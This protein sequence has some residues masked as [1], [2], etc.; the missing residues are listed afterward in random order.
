MR[1]S[2]ML[3]K[4]GSFWR[5]LLGREE[6]KGLLR[7]AQS[8]VPELSWLLKL[9]TVWNVSEPE[10]LT[11]EYDH[12]DIPPR[13][14][15]VKQPIPRFPTP[16]ALILK[17]PSGTKRQMLERLY[18][19]YQHLILVR[20]VSDRS[21]AKGVFDGRSPLRQLLSKA[22]RE[23]R[24]TSSRRCA[25]AT[26]V[27]SFLSA[28]QT[29]DKVETLYPNNMEL[30]SGAADAWNELMNAHLL[31]RT[32]SG[33]SAR[34]CCSVSSARRSSGVK[35]PDSQHFSQSQFSLPLNGFA[36]NITL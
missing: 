18:F 26:Q 34:R 14:G 22:R 5:Y 24:E 4:S 6:T 17:L 19:D 3:G 2:A 25:R 16:S 33:T 21:M 27:Y 10:R 23:S 32:R 31:R 36:S 12:L 29:D 15:F 35:V 20:V 8:N 11:I 28:A 13:A 30:V 1:S 7:F 9:S